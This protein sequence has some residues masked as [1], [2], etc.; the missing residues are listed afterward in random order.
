[1]KSLKNILIISFSIMALLTV[2]SLSLFFNFRADRLF[3]QYAKKQ[4][5]T[6]IDQMIS[7]VNQLYDGHTGSFDQSGI[8]II[9]YA[10]LQN[11]YI[12]HL[13]TKNK[14]IDW[15]VRT[16]HS[17]ECK[18]I[19]QHAEGVMKEKYP[20]FKGSY[21]EEVYTLKKDGTEYGVLKVG[22]Y[23][24]YSLSD[25]ELELMG[26]LNKSLLV[27]GGAALFGAVVLGRLIARAIS[28]PIDSVIAVA[29]KIAGGEYG[30]KAREAGGMR[31]TSHL[32]GAINEMS[33]ALE[34]EERQKRQITAD[35]A[36][37][38]RTPLTNLQSHMEA[39]IDGIWEPTLKRL[40]SCHA[41]ILRLV[42]IVEQLQELYSLENSDRELCPME[43]DFKELCDE[44]F[45][46][47]EIKLEKKQIHPVIEV[48]P[49][50]MLY[51]DYYRI[52]QCMVNLLSNALTYTQTGGIVKVKY[53]AAENGWHL[54][55]I[56]DNGTGVPE[57]ELSYL[58]ER[59][60]RVDKSRS[61]KTGGMGIGLSITRA[62]VE[63]H[64]GRIYAENREEGGLRFSIKLPD[65]AD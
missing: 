36:H 51:G 26:A 60:Y 19:L 59:F 12:I 10:A 7:Q 8:E 11:G 17:E 2:L 16:H 33:L 65:K 30:V 64:G 24:P 39:M 21:T 1:M 45:H 13:E 61:K 5:K 56:E 32:I 35:V 57:E 44:V 29:Q 58:F 48:L 3:E 55:T 40:E 52:K 34:K 20:H 62:I 50:Q 63:K 27:I 25:Q 22:Y 46:D 9:G 53:K 37:E 42:K 15:D 49:G 6:Q 54:I 14:D 28:K 4:Q 18:G 43:F 38:L 31:E 47:F 23:G 41:E